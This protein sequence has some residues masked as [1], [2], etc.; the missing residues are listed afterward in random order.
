MEKYS[1]TKEAKRE[2]LCLNQ[3]K[4]HV[5]DFKKLISLT[6]VLLF[7]NNPWTHIRNVSQARKQ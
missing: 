6:V 1:Q 4:I 2:N 5:R 7:S 3:V